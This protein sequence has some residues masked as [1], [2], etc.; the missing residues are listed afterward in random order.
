MRQTLVAQLLAI[1]SGLVLLGGIAGF[2]MAL[3]FVG[4]TLRC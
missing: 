1:A 3:V 2:A 4:H